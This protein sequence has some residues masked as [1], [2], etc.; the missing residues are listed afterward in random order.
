LLV[1]GGVFLFYSISE[2]LSA[3]HEINLSLRA[4]TTAIASLPQAVRDIKTR[5]TV[6]AGT[7]EE[8]SDDGDLPIL[9]ELPWRRFGWSLIERANGS[10][11]ERLPS[12]LAADLAKRFGGK[13]ADAFVGELG[14]QAA[15]AAL[16]LFKADEHSTGAPVSFLLDVDLHAG[17]Q[18]TL[19]VW[20]VLFDLNEA[21]VPVS[22]RATIHAAGRRAMELSRT[23]VVF[24]STD[25]LG[26]EEHNQALAQDRIQAVRRVLAEKGFDGLVVL[27]VPLTGFHRPIRTSD[28]I[29]EPANRSAYLLLL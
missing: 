9:E 8:S 22:G 5:A 18:A 24:G 28:E 29:S 21:T 10:I 25:T 19:P 13:F 27:E 2:V 15:K 17:S 20:V 1:L 14:S 7:S 3:L 12:T 6:G 11:K 4:Q 23:L 26:G 16:G